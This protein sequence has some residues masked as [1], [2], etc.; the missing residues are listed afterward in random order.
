M[1]VRTKKTFCWFCHANCA[2]LADVEDGKIVAVHDDPEFGGY[3]CVKDQHLP[4]SHNAAHRL[5]A[6][7]SVARMARSSKPRLPR[8]W[9]MLRRN[10]Q[11]DHRRARSRCRGDLHGFGRI[12]EQRRVSGIVQPRPGDRYAQLLLRPDHVRA[13]PSPGIAL[14]TSVTLDQPAKGITTQRYGQVDGWANTFAE[15]D[16]GFT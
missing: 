8:R 14:D 16:V 4:D 3:T 12:P 2:M 9:L 7:W 6:A 15:A 11:G 5:T 10:A 1:A 13:I